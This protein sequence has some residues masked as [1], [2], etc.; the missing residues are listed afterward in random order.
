MSFLLVVPRQQTG[1]SAII[2]VD[3]SLHLTI[4]ITFIDPKSNSGQFRLFAGSSSFGLSPNF[5]WNQTIFRSLVGNTLT[6]SSVTSLTAGILEE[7]EE[8][9]L[10]VQVCENSLHVMSENKHNVVWCSVSDSEIAETVDSLQVWYPGILESPEGV[11]NLSLLLALG[12][13]KKQIILVLK[14][15]PS[16]IHYRYQQIKDKISLILSIFVSHGITQKEF[17]MAVTLNSC[18]L[19][20][21]IPQIESVLTFLDE[22]LELERVGLVV[23]RAPAL[24]RM[25]PS[26]LREKYKFLETTGIKD[27]RMFIQKSPVILGLSI[28]ALSVK[29]ENLKLIMGVEYPVEHIIS[30]HVRLLNMNPSTLL[31]SY[32]KLLEVFSEELVR[33]MIVSAPHVL[34]QCPEKISDA[35]YFVLHTMNRDLEEVLRHP[36]ILSYS[37]EKR[38]IPRYKACVAVGKGDL[39]MSY[40]FATSNKEF[41]RR[42]GTSLYSSSDIDPELE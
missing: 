2:T 8:Q 42:F 4:P 37:L 33:K 30:R 27:V 39:S 20:S 40:I 21:S 16:F 17:C 11:R 7:S 25:S 1:I 34:S 38:L 15:L 35:L 10:K 19:G 14:R 23:S 6:P 18:F 41:D 26:K 24:L 13:N 5:L 22:E 12:M 9:D 31:R 32:Q 28:D 29:L 36:S 3:S